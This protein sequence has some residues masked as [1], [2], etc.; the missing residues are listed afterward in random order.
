VTICIVCPFDRWKEVIDRGET[1]LQQL[2][3]H[4]LQPRLDLMLPTSCYAMALYFL[5]EIKGW[6]MDSS[7]GRFNLT[8]TSVGTAPVMG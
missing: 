7:W 8:L 2:K 6:T 4:N 1:H 5:L 3:I